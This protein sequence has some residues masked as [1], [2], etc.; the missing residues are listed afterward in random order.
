MERSHKLK[1]IVDR[2]GE[3]PALPEIVTEVM[4]LTDDPSA[5]MTEV[6][7]AIQRDPAL[8][9]RI[10][11]VSNSA[12][13]GLKQHVGTLRLA[14]VVLGI[15]EIRNIVLSVSCFDALRDAQVDKALAR[16]FYRHSFIVAGIAR[17]LC[18]RI[19]L[20]AQGEAFVSGVL[21]D[22]G[23][24]VLL[25]QFG[26]AYASVYWECGGASGPLCEAEQKFA[27]FTHAD[28]A[29]A[30][31]AHWD[32]PKTLIDALWFHHEQP[33]IVL[34]EA[35]DPQLAAAVRIANTAAHFDWGNRQDI[36]PEL[37]ADTEAWSYL[38]KA[39]S[40]VPEDARAPLLEE[41]YGAVMR[42]PIPL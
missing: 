35:K 5:D 18:E 40:P 4:R 10:L 13:Y 39:K 21:H 11:R 24:L 26:D 17:K 19:G 41:L 34:S 32:F 23:K 36:G 14:L 6:G 7:D 15:T 20:D 33:G 3:L 37:R 28:A 12:Y 25:R 22:I 9:A 2:S 30:L 8:T 1:D 29:A 42:H 38:S 31:A 16:D 27:G